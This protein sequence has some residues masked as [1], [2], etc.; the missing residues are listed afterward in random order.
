MNRIFFINPRSLLLLIVFTVGAAPVIALQESSKIP[1][2]VG[3]PNNA[4]V[5]IDF[6]GFLPGNIDTTLSGKFEVEFRLYRSPQG[7]EPVWREHHLL[8]VSGGRVDVKLGSKEPIPMD[9]HEATF[10]WIGASVGGQR[11]IFPRYHVVN[12]VYVSF[13]EALLAR[14][15]AQTKDVKSGPYATTPRIEVSGITEKASTWREALIHARQQG[16]DL[17]GFED[18]YGSIVS[19]TTTNIEE[20]TGH[21]EWVLPWAYDSASHGRYN[22]FFRGRFKGCDYMDLSPQKQYVYRM[23]QPAARR[24]SSQDSQTKEGAR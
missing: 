13:K 20:R 22:E 17:A 19:P 16:R 14:E 15:P 24:N 9:I 21:Y 6:N 10:K 3:E 23:A 5:T 7:G 18:W 8:D 1:G 12:V 4:P 11:E 2:N